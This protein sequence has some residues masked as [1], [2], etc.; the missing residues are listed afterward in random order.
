MPLHDFW[1]FDHVPQGTTDLSTGSGGPVYATKTGTYYQLTGNPGYAY[2]N[3]IASAVTVGSDGYL[4]LGSNSTSNPGLAIQAKEV[5]DWSVA[6]QYWVGFR[7][8]TS[9]QN[10]GSAN[11]FTMSDT[12]GQANPS[13]LVLE[14]DMTAAGANTL[15]QDYMV[16]VFIDRSAKTYQVW[17]NGVQVKN[18]TIAAATLANGQ[19]GFYWFGPWNSS[20]NAN[21]NRF[22]RD[23]YWVDVDATQ[24]PKRLGSVRTNPALQAGLSAPTYLYESVT[25]VGTAAV[26][27]A[28]AKFGTQSLT[29]GSSPTTS[30][31]IVPEAPWNRFG[32]YGDCTLECWVYNTNPAQGTARLF[33]KD[34][35]ASPYATVDYT[36]AGSWQFYMD[37][38]AVAMSGTGTLTANTWYHVALVRNAGTWYFYLN[39]VKICSVLGNTW[40]NQSTA[41]FR[42]GNWSSLAYPWPGYIDGIRISNVAR[43]PG[44]TTFTPPS[45]AFTNDANTL[46]LLN[47]E[48]NPFNAIHDES[49]PDQTNPSQNVFGTVQ[50]ASPLATTVAPSQIAP[51][52]GDTLTAQF[53]ASPLPPGA[54]ILAV[55]Y[56]VAAQSNQ[57]SLGVQLTDGT[58]NVNPGSYTF[59]DPYTLGYG[60][61]VALQ[62]SAPDSGIWTPAKVGN[63]KLKLT[64]PAA[65]KT[66]ALLHMEDFTDAAGRTWTSNGNGVLT[67]T[68]FKFGSKSYNP[69][70]SG[71]L[72]VALDNTLLLSNVFTI[73][74]WVYRT[75]ALGDTTLL[76]WKTAN[77]STHQT[78]FGQQA[79]GAVGVYLT[80]GGGWR[81]LA[82]S[83]FTLNAWNH[84][85]VT[86][87]NGI[88]TGYING[89][90]ALTFASPLGFGVGPGATLTIGGNQYNTS[91]QFPG[92]IDEVRVSNV[93]RYNANFLPPPAPFAAVDN[94]QL[95]SAFGSTQLTS[96]GI[97]T[98][99]TTTALLLPYIAQD[100]KANIV[101]EDIVNAPVLAGATTVTLTAAAGSVNFASG[102]TVTLTFATN[103][104]Q[105]STM[106][107]HFDGTSGATTTTDALGHAMTMSNS[108]A[109]SGSQAKFGGTSLNPNVT[110]SSVVSTPDAP[111]LRFGVSGDCTIEFWCMSTNNGQNGVVFAKDLSSSSYSELQYFTGTWRV[112]LDS[113]SIAISATSGVPANTWMHIAL[114][115]YN[116]VWTLYQN[117]VSLGTFSGGTL[118]NNSNPFLIGNWGGRNAQW[119]GYIDE[120]RVSNVARYTAAFTP[121]VFAFTPD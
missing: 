102:S 100:A 11:V 65:A 66:V 49:A 84:L 63:A 83:T 90:Q 97:P 36:S 45:A 113:T 110:T 34:L 50:A 40:G 80:D 43:Y 116:G 53:A 18:G 99:A 25:A 112:Y 28:Q 4:K 70:S 32:T 19:N 93:V 75:S 94:A 78:T 111:E 35:A 64:P 54:K 77:D 56:R 52:S 41:L 44:G 82:S 15:N 46:M 51:S 107:L 104:V 38:G 10:A 62:T 87:A 2:N 27:N 26:T 71:N 74:M 23:I 47:F 119:Q 60:R 98:G 106:L 61:R 101:P 8:K 91:S 9:A 55:D 17:I 59:A 30:A 5:Q 21:A 76:S 37:S 89:V 88:Y 24:T 73:E 68:Q 81:L 20:L 3:G 7:T 42:I 16:E 13:I 72:S 33:S 48:P 92:Y 79:G 58:N 120:F 115:K 103:Q 57:S 67:A 118:G 121:P 86:Y 69:G 39:G 14:S 114:V 12:I 105:K 6:T 109:L 1:P 31:L 85:A 108:A 29:M 95:S 96:T 117:G 22:F